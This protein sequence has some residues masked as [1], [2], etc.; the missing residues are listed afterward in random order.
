MRWQV[1]DISLDASASLVA[2]VALLLVAGGCEPRVQR[3]PVSGR[4]LIDGEPLTSG[5]IRFVPE[6]GRPAG[7]QIAADGSFRV[8]SVSAADKTKVAGLVAG[9]YR[10]AV[11]STETLGE[12][13]DAEVRWLIPSH[14]GSFRTSDLKVDIQGPTESLMIELTWEGHEETETNGETGTEESSRSE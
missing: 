11:S 7:S 8:V 10:V 14:Y 1:R 5:S 4:V 12:S 3:F 2:C 9:H 13:E 6:S